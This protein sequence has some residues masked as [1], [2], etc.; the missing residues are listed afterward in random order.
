MP[1]TTTPSRRSSLARWSAISLIVFGASMTIVACGSDD[2]SDDGGGPSNLG[3][4]GGKGGAGGKAGTG[5]AVAGGG[6]SQGG[7]GTTNIGG[8]N[9]GGSQNPG[10]NG[11]GGTNPGGNGPGGN[12]QGGG[13]QAQGGECAGPPGPIQRKCRPPTDNECDGYTDKS[14]EFKPDGA[15]GNGFDDDCDGLVDEGCACPGAGKTKDCFLLPS[16]QTNGAPSWEPQ[17][18]CATNSKGKVECKVEGSGEFKNLKYTGQCI[19]AQGPKEEVCE[20]GDF[21]CDGLNGNAA[22]ICECQ[23]IVCPDPIYTTPFPDPNNIGQFSNVPNGPKTINGVDGKSWFKDSNL[24]GKTTNWRWTM[25]GGPCDDILPNPTFALFP[26]NVGTPSVPWST[27][28]G[29]KTLSLPKIPDEGQ[30]DPTFSA[31][32]ADKFHRGWVLTDAPSK[33]FP[34]FSLSGDYYITGK[35][36]YPDPASPDQL[37]EGQCTQVVKVRAPGLRVELCWPEV[38]PNKDDND[39]DLHLSRLQNNPGGDGKHGWFTTAGNAPNADDCY[40]SPNSACGNRYNTNGSTA[41]TPSW[42]VDEITDEPGG[43]G[44]CHGWGSRRFDGS[45]AGTTKRDCTSPRLD[46]DNI[47]CNPTIEDPNAPEQDIK[48]QGEN[49]NNFCGPENINLDAKVL[50]QGQRFAIGVQCYNCVQGK[51]GSG[52]PAHPRVNIYCDGELKLGF[53]YDPSKPEG[54]AQSPA[55][56]TE[57]QTYHGSFWNVATVTWNGDASDP[58]AINPVEAGPEWKDNS[59][60]EQSNGSEFLCVQNG[61]LDSGGSNFAPPTPNTINWKFNSSGS[62]PDASDSNAICAYLAPSHHPCSPS[63]RTELHFAGSFSCL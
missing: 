25:V 22:N 55:L 54:E 20:T 50:T 33:V 34:A 7:G 42:Y 11:P 35:F 12:A 17:G 10:G 51:N 15:E 45:V 13:G 56:V 14:S 27:H 44:V 43:V 52:K 18:W 9:P 4:K 31:N 48:Q 37:K 39:V 59:W 46:R 36:Q 24:A 19:G 5:G 53:G 8:Q 41:I 1:K 26:T 32:I 47:S 28:L 58:C 3:G 62:Y 23:P 38:G 60:R 2:T 6:Q 63:S 21:N 29:T 30:P 49:P 61:P 57:G 16:T 40:Y